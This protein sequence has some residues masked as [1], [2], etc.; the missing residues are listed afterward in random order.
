[1]ARYAVIYEDM[2][3]DTAAP[4][5]LKDHAE[6]LKDLHSRGILL[7]WGQLK[8]SGGKGLLIF[9]AKS[10]EEVEGHVLKDPFITVHKCYATYH[11]Y[12]WLKANG[13]TGS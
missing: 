6:H 5:L 12:E 2:R 11:I 7:M 3:E 8:D 9:E 4:D 1:M 10:R 13:S